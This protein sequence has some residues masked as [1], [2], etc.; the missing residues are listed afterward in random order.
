[1]ISGLQKE[2]GIP[3]NKCCVPEPDTLRS[4]DPGEFFRKLE[5]HRLALCFTDR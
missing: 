2:E 1:M 3:E 4:M 5:V